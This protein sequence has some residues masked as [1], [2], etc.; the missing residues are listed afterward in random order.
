[1]G[2]FLGCLNV[3]EDNNIVKRGK[4]EWFYVMRKDISF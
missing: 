2:Y 3:K 1:M 4:I